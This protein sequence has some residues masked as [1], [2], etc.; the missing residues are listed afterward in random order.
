[1]NTDNIVV[2]TRGPRGWGE[3][4]N[5]EK[6]GTSVIV[7]TIKKKSRSVGPNGLTSEFYHSKKI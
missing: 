2:K 6:R 5:G 4:Q 1:M 3:G 7:P